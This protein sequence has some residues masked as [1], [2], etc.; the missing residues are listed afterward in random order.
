MKFLVYPQLT[1]LKAQ[2]L[3]SGF[4]AEK[5]SEVNVSDIGA[6]DLSEF[7]F[8]PVGGNRVGMKDLLGL[9]K[10]ILE[11]ASTY[12]FPTARARDLARRF[13]IDCAK[14]L[15]TEM[16]ISPNEAARDGIWNFLSCVLLPDVAR[17][18]FPTDTARAAEDR[19]LSGVRNTF[20]RLWWRA[21]VLEDVSGLR[22]Y[23]ML[24]L[25]NEDELVQLMERPAVSASRQLSSAICRSFVMAIRASTLPRMTLMREAQ[26][27][28]IRLLPFVSFESLH[29]DE[30]LAVTDG[31]LTATLN[32]MKAAQISS[33]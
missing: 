25:L 3:V 29:E 4:S 31:I 1:R 13:D 26:K 24:E 7:S 23:E 32:E 8:S 20:Q 33:G 21:Y 16:H 9:R 11:L 5:T 19:L 2:P 6:M 14:I 17:W 30:L 15:H 27:R 12:G 22:P 28:L 10:S 18:R